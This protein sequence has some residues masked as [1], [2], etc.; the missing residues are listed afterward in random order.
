MKLK[1]LLLGIF[2]LGML[3]LAGCGGGAD[4]LNGSVTV[5]AKAEGSVITGTATYK[6][7][8]QTNLIG[9]PMSFFYQVGN[10][11][12][13]HLED[14]VANNS[15][16]FDFAFTP[17]SFIGSQT[18]TVIVTAGKLSGFATVLMTGTSLT[19]TPPPKVDLTTSAASGTSI[20][21]TIPATATF[22]SLSDPLN[23]DVVGHRIETTVSV[24]STNPFT[25]VTPTITITDASGT[26]GFPGTTGT[27]TVPAA[28]L[29][30][31]TMTIIWTV[32]DLDSGATGSGETTVTLTKSS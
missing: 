21:F 10:S 14:A 6:N 19:V 4:G 12:R 32:F 28:V 16:A 23:N 11:P 5:T 27:L 15:G 17:G 26:A 24:T 30:V 7:P 22:V 1:N 2:S 3:A 18:V 29:G 20:G 25:L 13:I 31:E 8:T 9:Q